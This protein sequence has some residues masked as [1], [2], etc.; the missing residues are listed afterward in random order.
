M[1]ERH[2]LNLILF[3]FTC[4][5]APGT[6]L[7]PTV[8]IGFD[9][10]TGITDGCK[11]PCGCWIKWGAHNY[12][13]ISPAPEETILSETCSMNPI[14]GEAVG[15]YQLSPILMWV[16]RDR[17]CQEQTWQPVSNKSEVSFDTGLG[18]RVSEPSRFSG[19]WNQTTA[20]KNSCLLSERQWIQP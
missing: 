5:Y 15:A 18:T 7:I 14:P 1:E 3:A 10:E 9:P 6:C 16:G 19:K 4:M 8:A 2:I 17:F 12:W 13:T 11:P 20:L